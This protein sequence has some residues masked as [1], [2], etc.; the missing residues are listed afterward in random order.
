MIFCDNI[1]LAYL[2]NKNMDNSE[3]RSYL[4]VESNITLTQSVVK[5]LRD[6]YVDS[7]DFFQDKD[8]NEIIFQKKSTTQRQYIDLLDYMEDTDYLKRYYHL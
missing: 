5:H 8:I 3:G 2:P 1:V 7:F 4:S 6:K